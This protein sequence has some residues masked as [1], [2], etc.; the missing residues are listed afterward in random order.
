MP[1]HAPPMDVLRT[2]VSYMSG[3]DSERDDSTQAANMRKALR[4][5]AQLATIVATYERIR[6]GQRVLRPDPTLGHAEDFV[7][8][9]TGKRPDPTWARMM[10]VAMVLYADHGMNASTFGATVA[11]ST[12]AD[13]HSTIVA[14]IATLK[15]PL[16]GGAIEDA[17]GLV[18]TIRRPE[19]APEFIVNKLRNK[20]K[21]PGFGHRVYKTYDP[22]ALIMKEYARQLAES[23]GDD[24]YFRIA[25][26]IE[27]TVVGELASKRIFPNV[28][29]YSGLVF[30]RLGISTDL[31]TPVFAL[32]RAPGW[33]AHVLEYWEDNRLLRPLDWYVGPKDLA[34]VP[35]DERA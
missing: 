13:L 31:F 19:A 24:T 15:G 29:F 21:V 14:A 18:E 11:A 5:T 12:R 33:T 16:H 22:R 23:K 8:M 27:E 7:R 32:S 9:V 2:A 34:Y 3:F 35:L 17:L 10:D 1:E 25:T 4:I 28:D 30:H 26:A 6:K 20:E